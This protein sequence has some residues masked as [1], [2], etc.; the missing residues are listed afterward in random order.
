MADPLSITASIIAILQLT[1]EVIKYSLDFK[2][3]PKAILSLKKNIQSLQKLLE[4]LKNRCENTL[5]AYKST[6][7]WLQC[8]W[9]VRCRTLQDRSYEYKYGGFI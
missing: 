4:R 8:L 7:P 9:E 1:N 5:H 2:N 6:P 3:A